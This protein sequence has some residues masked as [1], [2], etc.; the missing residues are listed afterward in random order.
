MKLRYYLRGL[1][2]GV[3]ITTIILSISLYGRNK[4]LTDKEII[5]RAKEL[6]M[7]EQEKN[8]NNQ[9]QKLQDL[10]E[11]QENQSKETENKKKPEKKEQD[12]PKN[13][14]ENVEKKDTTSE[15][16]KEMIQV[17]ITGGLGSNAIAELL[18]NAKL[19]DDAVAFNSFLTK[20]N[21]DEKLGAGAFRIPM[22][23]TYEEVAKILIEK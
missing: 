10:K 7:V 9:S 21:Y 14:N 12:I 3:I 20:N 15:K 17:D 16:T 23:A 4:S 2:V 19:V 1:G 18:F 8:K 11:E 13:K 22:G 6:G 5:E